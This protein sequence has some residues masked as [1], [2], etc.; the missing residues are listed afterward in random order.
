MPDETMYVLHF[1]FEDGSNPIYW[2]RRTMEEIADILKEWSK[3]WV[4]KPAK[5]SSGGYL[6]APLGSVSR[7]AY[8]LFFVLR[9]K[10]KKVNLFMVEEEADGKRTDSEEAK[11]VS[12]E[13]PV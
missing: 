2:S 8:A 11:R 12:A 10:E 1:H 9:S 6:C 4:L 3:N 13:A 7:D 5:L